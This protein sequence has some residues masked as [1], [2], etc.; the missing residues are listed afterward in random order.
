MIIQG[1]IDIGKSYLI[2]DIKHSLEIESLPHKTPLLLLDPIT[3]AVFNIFTMTIHYALHILVR[4]TTIL[5]GSCLITLQ[6]EMIHIKYTIIDEMSFIG[7]NLLMGECKKFVPEKVAR[8][9]SKTT[10]SQ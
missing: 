6:E 3:V 4:D 1:T 9:M 8:D 10:L 5:Q 7:G 2:C